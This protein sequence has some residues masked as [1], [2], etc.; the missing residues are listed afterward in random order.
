MSNA[1]SVVRRAAAVVLGTGAVLIGTAA[2]AAAAPVPGCTAGDITA[3]ESGVAAAMTGYFFTHP[4]V[5]D[6]FTSVQGLPKEEARSKTKAYLAANPQTQ[7]EIN[8]IRGP[9]LDLRNRCGIPTNNII[10]GVL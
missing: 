2:T 5:N 8:S 6:F 9:V 10:R 3:V 7:A 4:A 1:V